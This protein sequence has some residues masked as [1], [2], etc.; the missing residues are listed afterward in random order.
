MSAAGNIADALRAAAAQAPDRVAMQVPAGR[1]G[2]RTRFSPLTYGELD[3]DSDAIAAGALA[4]GLAPGTRVALMVRPGVP[5]FVLMFGLF[6]AGLVPVLVDP[7]IDRRAL[8]AC[9]DEAEP[10]AFF[11]IPLA[12][13]ARLVLGWA[14]RSNRYNLTVGAR[15]GWGGTTYAT[16][17]ER[18]RAALAAGAS[19]PATR[20]DDL[21]AILFTSGSTGLPK[22]VEY[23]HR[24][25]LAQVELIR[26]AFGIRAGEVDLPTFP[27]FALF[28]PGLGMTSVIPEMDPTR[29]ARANPARLIATIEQ[30]GC[31]TMFGSP[32]LLDTLT[33]HAEARGIR[34]DS[35]RRVLSAGAP[36]RPDVIA[37]AYRMLPADAE[38][39]TPY[40][41]T[42]CLP[43]AVIEGREILAQSAGR[44]DAGAG[45]CVGRPLAANTVRVIAIDD[46]AIADWHEARELPAGEIG[47]ITVTGPSVTEAYFR[48]D[49]ATRLAKIRE[50]LRDGSSRIVHRMGDVGYYDEDGRLWYCGRKSHRVDTPDAT[51]YSECVEGIFNAVPGVRR[52]AL[53]GVGPRGRQVPVVCIERWHGAGEVGWLELKPALIARGAQFPLTAGLS[54]FLEHPAFPVD[55]RHNAKI[56]REQLAMWA[57]MRLPYE[58][59]MLR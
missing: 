13:L 14:R 58:P 50:H 59:G 26:A 51:L 49:E 21:A 32:A 9:L 4:D 12:H 28:D 48:R 52:S 36:V 10:A 15:L 8:K 33:R 30:H 6:K 44:T 19:L 23:R 2:A 25:F 5:F 47:E 46:G 18:G 56:G 24:M 11:G 7:G 3:R 35:L 45:I 22:G 34:V 39:W 31:T 55:I 41:A 42:E 1:D 53:V 16:L 43:V 40:G 54:V 20:A 57:G 27:P 29:P 17:L 37:R 38:L